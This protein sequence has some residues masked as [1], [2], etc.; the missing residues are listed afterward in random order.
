[1]ESSFDAF[2]KAILSD[3][4]RL[5]PE[6]Y[7]VGGAVRDHLL[8]QAAGKDLD[9]AVQGDGFVIAEKLA[10]IHAVTFV[11]LDDSHGSG[12]IVL[13]AREPITVD[14]A[15]FRGADIMTDLKMR[16]FTINALGVSLK[17]YMSGRFDQILDPTGGISDIRSKTIRVCS[18]CSFHDDPLRILRTFRFMA[19]LGF[20]VEAHTLNGIATELPGLSSAAPERIRDEFLA[21]LAAAS[22]FQALKAMD[23]TGVLDHLFPEL[24]SMRGC[25][26]NE[27]HHLDVWK[28]SLEAVSQLESL[29]AGRTLYFGD[30]SH[31]VENYLLEEPVKGRPR[32]ALLKLAA[33]FHDSGK[34]RSRFVEPG[35]RVR[36]F[37]HETISRKI[38]EEA[39]ERIKLANREI[40]F[41]GDLVEGHMRPMIFTGQPVS[42]RA[43]LRMR[44]RFHKDVVGLFLLFLADL[45]A[46]R[47]L[48]RTPE[49][50]QTARTQ[51]LRALEICFEAAKKKEEPFLNGRDL[52]ELFGMEPGPRM[53]SILKQLRELQELGDITSKAQAI[54]VTNEMLQAGEPS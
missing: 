39:G 47:G 21:T 3:V 54:E 24:G 14:I 1:M 30:S 5:A 48:A 40:S 38:F 46:T 34:P 32:A 22:S 29:I 11:P 20:R 15:S 19:G 44:R 37:G 23:A 50:E 35:G 45:A 51:V 9:L 13:K 18:D 49:S 43:I 8:G 6:A 4:I 16:D 26:Q 52:M 41:I 25:G 17:D 28:H 7:A 27:F 31:L 36:F 53:G 33:L 2:L 12:R 10:D 42:Q